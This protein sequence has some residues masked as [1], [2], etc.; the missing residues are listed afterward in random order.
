MK[1]AI[2]I[3]L[4]VILAL[5]VGDFKITFSPFSVSLPGW[6]KIIAWTCFVI[7]MVML[8]V[9]S[10]RQGLVKGADLMGDHIIKVMQES[11][12]MPDSTTVEDAK[13]EIIE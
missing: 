10:F 4:F 6:I 8:E 5:I 12:Q 1:T 11:R 3:L 2:S 13:S 7:G 9:H